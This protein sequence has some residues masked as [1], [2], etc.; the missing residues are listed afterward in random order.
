MAD[1][2]DVTP[3][4]GR[5]IATDEV[6][7]RNFQLVKLVDGTAESTAPLP[8]SATRGLAVDPRPLVARIAATPA[9]SLTAYAAKDAVGGLMTFAGAA[10][11]A[12]G[13]CRLSGLQ[14]VDLAQQM[15]SMDLLLFDR[16]I[17][18]PTDNAIFAP[19]DAELAYCVGVVPI[20]SGYFA[21]LS[22]NAVAN[23]PVSLDI[24]LNGTDLFAVLVA[25]EAATFASVADLVLSLTL[26]KS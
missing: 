16:T 12:G 11:T 25:R 14:V 23:V 15:K 5:T 20:G 26:S 2:I 13:A 19:T 6:G 9:I 1:D 21:D 18:A 7:T 24:V 17:T 22:T 10:R 3:G 4:T 8:G